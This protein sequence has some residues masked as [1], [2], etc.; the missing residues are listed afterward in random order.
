MSFSRKF[1]CEFFIAMRALEWLLFQMD[2]T[3]T[4]QTGAT[5]KCFAAYLT[6]ERFLACIIKP[7]MRADSLVVSFFF[8]TCV[9]PVV[10]LKLAWIA[11]GE[12][13]TYE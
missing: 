7:K 11:E 12:V 9:Y 13:A 2:G 6:F 8:V 3:V 10:S 5:S 1:K 4:R